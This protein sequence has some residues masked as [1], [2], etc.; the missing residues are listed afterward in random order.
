M[1]KATRS[2]A[3]E[4][5]S[6][7]PELGPDYFIQI[8]QTILK[9]SGLSDGAFRLYC[10]LLTY[11]RQKL[12]AW[13]GQET[14]AEDM[15]R[16]VRQVRT[17]LSQLKDIGLVDWQ[18]NGHSSNRYHVFKAPL[19]SRFTS[20]RKD[21]SGLDRK[22]SSGLDRKDSSAESH[23][24]EQHKIEQHHADGE[25]ISLLNKEGFSPRTSEKLAKLLAANSRPVDYLTGWLEYVHSDQEIKRP[26]GFLRSMIEENQNLPRP[27]TPAER[28]AQQQASK[29]AKWQKL[30][31]KKRSDPQ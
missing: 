26:L 13:P 1:P 30:S 6:Y 31:S 24:L 20:D 22:D 7:D 4:P 12:T 8:P 11:C 25:F 10:V 19:R 16:S 17:L 21:S 28:Q 5:L 14:L 23:E 9:D 27:A 15:G 3:V 18:Q 2:R 29:M